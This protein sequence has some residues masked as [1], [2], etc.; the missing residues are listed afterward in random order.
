MF[1]GIHR[2]GAA[3]FAAGPVGA[4]FGVVWGFPKQYLFDPHCLLSAAASFV[5]GPGKERVGRRDL[6]FFSV[7]DLPLPRLRFRFWLF[8]GW[9][10]FRVGF[11]LS[12]LLSLLSGFGRPVPLQQNSFCPA[13]VHLVDL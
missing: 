4:T 11:F 13:H 5:E 1:R 12:F 6:G 3:H 8:F 2:S 7:F 10:F 9:V